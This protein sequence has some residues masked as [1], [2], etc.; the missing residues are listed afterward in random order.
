MQLWSP[1]SKY[2]AAYKRRCLNDKNQKYRFA[3]KCLTEILSSLESFADKT[4]KIASVPSKASV[5]RTLSQLAQ[6]ASE[7]QEAIEWMEKADLVPLTKEL[8][9]AR[10][11][12]SAIRLTTL[13][14]QGAFVENLDD[15]LGTAINSLAD[16]LKGDHAELDLLLLETTAFRKVIVN[17]FMTE[18]SI[19]DANPTLRSL[20]IAAV[21]GCV[22]FLLR[23]LGTAPAE[24][25]SRL[26][27]D[28]Y[29]E[30]LIKARTAAP[31]FID[32]VL[33]CSNSGVRQRTVGWNLL[34]DA[35][36]DCTTLLLQLHR[37]YFEGTNNNN[38]KPQN[39]A[40]TIK[41]LSCIYWSYYIQNNRPTS[42]KEA[43]Q[44]LHRSIQV[45]HRGGPEAKRIGQVSMKIETLAAFYERKGAIREALATLRQLFLHHVE[46]GL[47]DSLMSSA[48][49]CAYDSLWQSSNGIIMARCVDKYH[50]LQLACSSM[51]EIYPSAIDVEA[52]G[53]VL[54]RHLRLYCEQLPNSRPEDYESHFERLSTVL[55]MLLEIYDP[56]TYPI[57][58]M[59]IALLASQL[60]TYL[61]EA[62]MEDV[63]QTVL[64]SME[65]STSA[66]SSKDRLLVQYADHLRN[67]IQL[68]SML[69]QKDVPDRDFGQLIDSW[70]KIVKTSKASI[71]DR[72]DHIS[73]FCR[74]LQLV[75]DYMGVKYHPLLRTSSLSLLSTIL[76]YQEDQLSALVESSS[77][78]ALEY[79]HLGHTGEAKE[80]LLKCQ[81]FVN[82]DSVHPGSKAYFHLIYAE[83]YLTIGSISESEQCL[84]FA[85]LAGRICLGIGSDSTK[86][87][88][89][90]IAKLKLYRLL[91]LALEIS[92]HFYS[93]TGVP[94][95][96]LQ[97]MTRAARLL[98][99]IW[100][101]L[102]NDD[103][104]R[105]SSPSIEIDVSQSDSAM[106][107]L[108]AK[109][110][111]TSMTHE[112]LNG[113]KLWPV[114]PALRRCYLQ[115]ASLYAHIG[116]FSESLAWA[117][118]AGKIVDAV[119]SSSARL[120]HRT[121]MANLWL[122]AEEIERGQEYLDEAA[123][124][125]N[126]KSCLELAQ[127]HHAISKMWRARGE[128]DDEIEALDMSLQVIDELLSRY[129]SRLSELVSAE[130]EIVDKLDNLT[131]ADPSNVTKKA[132][133]RPT[134]QK[135]AAARTIVEKHRKTGKVTTSKS[136]PA[137]LASPAEYLPLLADKMEILADKA[138]LLIRKDDFANA[139]LIMQ[140]AGKT[141]TGVNQSIR[142]KVLA[143][144]CMI[145]KALKVMSIDCTF[146]MLV[147][148][149]ICIPSLLIERRDSN[150]H[151][152]LTG[153]L[154]AN[155]GSKLVQETKTIKTKGN[156]KTTTANFRSLLRDAYDSLVEAQELA[157]QVASTSDYREIGQ[158]LATTSFYLSAAP[159]GSPKSMV[160]PADAASYLNKCRT[161]SQELLMHAA[162]LTKDDSTKAEITKWPHSE[163]ITAQKTSMQPEADFQEL[164]VDIIPESWSVVSLSLAKNKSDL[165]LNRY[166]SGQ[167][168]FN[169]KVPL[170]TSDSDGNDRFGF[171]EAREELLEIIELSTATT[172][173]GRYIDSK[174]GR[175]EWW[176]ERENLDL[177]MK[178]F[179]E[180]IEQMWLGGFKGLFT[181]LKHQPILFA[182]FQKGLQAALNRHLPSRKGKGR[183]KN[184]NLDP[185][186]IELFIGLGDPRKH[187]LDDGI[188][189][190]LYFVVD[191]LQFNGESNAY[192]EIDFDS[193]VVD[194]ISAL[195]AYYSASIDEGE[196]SHHTI[197][198]LDNEL[199]FLPWESI[200]AL[201]NHSV[202][203][204]PSLEALRTRIL[205]ARETQKTD[206]DSSY[207][208]SRAIGASVLNPGNDLTNTQKAISPLLSSLPSSW[209]HLPPAVPPTES[210]FGEA[211]SNNPLFLYFGHGS[212]SQFI[213]VR[214]VRAMHSNTAPVAWLMGCSS[215]ALTTRG[216][217]EPEGMVSAYLT[218]GAPA[219]V[220]TLWDVTDKDCDRAAVKMGELWGLWEA[221]EESKKLLALKGKQKAGKEQSM[222]IEKA[223][224]QGRRGKGKATAQVGVGGEG[225][226]RLEDRVDLCEAIRRGR[227]ECYLR[228]LNGAAL[229]VYGIPVML[230]P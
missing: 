107:D 166:R 148:S 163:I 36:Q 72:I 100:I 143:S 150:Q 32:S 37:D 35:L 217:F 113:A 207:F 45:L 125:I 157:Y 2:I 198:I 89:L 134:K 214:N 219:V 117:A 25:A 122:R 224:S 173:T 172:K 3:R 115:T 197:L 38:I 210:D 132:R 128:P 73:L 116:M 102:E 74:Q 121:F 43:E 145:H 90:N 70:K 109:P 230:D 160:H 18:E 171:E 17:A 8:S 58:R 22:R 52:K 221:G 169:L 184:I 21:L 151:Q 147:E 27:V 110:Q 167:T 44:A 108:S 153:S 174:A 187:E 178:T 104:K 81:E 34:D 138:L 65:Y 66:S 135:N 118:K 95:I 59:R 4:S 139:E 82:N 162:L 93:Q 57:R 195:E 7:C 193:I 188:V 60:K 85:E 144:Q 83:Y 211:I 47:V 12:S 206:T 54:E 180:N 192:D 106:M 64:H 77:M 220:G 41:R 56:S 215:V 218:A 168:P 69:S 123:E 98:Q 86:Q 136:S 141:Q 126:S 158:L 190:L 75:S 48:A 120:V 223:R 159:S 40:T 49:A 11:A 170:T 229:V 1:F 84:K 131:I 155:T 200:P 161:R 97:Y 140:T 79:L 68:S 5:Y 101:F 124:E 13:M 91:A 23:Y 67:G 179:L 76:E 46:S 213:R 177:R 191:I 216:E 133:G 203:R 39:T 19:Q 88:S 55:A 183:Q 15:Q 6:D 225:L 51:D 222:P 185:R 209:S 9:S 181:R 189:D 201:F 137:N 63:N 99:R 130:E 24:G 62:V 94:H 129:H 228:Y 202:S 154:E 204:L 71:T 194:T 142:D 199:H 111:V 31:G 50:S 42:R 196:A 26:D 176:E 212:G 114:V 14:L 205:A 165:L 164:Y 175:A 112:A 149:T 10:K 92:S 78:L 29:M 227:D 186:I 152:K 127:Y 96:A 16:S 208:I 53:V 87:K 119:P 80:V 61:P 156:K 30:K 20:Y 226:A 103:R 105:S 182:R 33:L 28:R 146:S